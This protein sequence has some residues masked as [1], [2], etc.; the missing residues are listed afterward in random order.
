MGSSATPSDARSAPRGAEAVAALAR[1]GALAAFLSRQRWFAAK[2][3]AIARVDVVDAALVEGDRP[4]VLA[5]IDVDGDR[6]HLPL[7]LRA[8]GEPAVAPPEREIGP[9][10]DR[11]VYDAH[12]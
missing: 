5:L 6:Y 12:W 4:F 8:A 11:V 9:V 10:G 2:D 7:A 1:S 3:R